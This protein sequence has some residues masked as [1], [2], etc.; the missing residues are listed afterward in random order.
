MNTARFMVNPAIY[1]AEETA[2]G[3]ARIIKVEAVDPCGMVS[4]LLNN[5][6]ASLL[7]FRRYMF[8][9]AKAMRD[10]LSGKKA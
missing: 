6:F 4:A 1:K 8:D 10:T 3:K 5:Y 9:E 7:F 2:P